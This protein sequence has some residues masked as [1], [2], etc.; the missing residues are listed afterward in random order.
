MRAASDCECVL[1]FLGVFGREGWVYAD[2]GGSRWVEL[3][4][5]PLFDFRLL[6][7]HKFRGGHRR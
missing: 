1:N 4:P 3:G 7:H 2:L 6:D 5:K